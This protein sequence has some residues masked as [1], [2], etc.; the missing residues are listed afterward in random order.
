MKRLPLGALWAGPHPCQSR[1]WP[2]EVP[3]FKFFPLRVLVWF[4]AYMNTRT[5][6]AQMVPPLFFF[7]LALSNAE[8][9]VL[10]F[11]LALYL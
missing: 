4:V 11:L 5:K 1:K 10:V 8:W 3:C 7:T 2:G 6:I 9:P